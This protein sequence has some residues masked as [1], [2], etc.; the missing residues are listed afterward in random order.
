MALN[1]RRD[2]S[3]APSPRVGFEMSVLRMLAFRPAEGGGVDVEPVARP[4]PAAN[5]RARASVA[6]E[7]TQS[8]PSVPAAAAVPLPA[9]PAPQLP[10]KTPA[11]AATIADADRWLELVA[12]SGLRGPA[13]EL[14]EHAGFLSHDN[15]VL[16]LSLSAADEHLKAPALVRMLAEGIAPALGAAPQIRFESA[17]AA[18]QTLHQRK[19]QQRD[20]RQVAA[21]AAFMADP[22]V[23]RLV[24]QHGA[25][26]V[27]DSIRPFDE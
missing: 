5:E 8:A 26:V 7:A 23:Q 27:P 2:L 22:G 24:S 25:S 6:S 15:G 14:A 17:Q 10:T 13:R 1:G 19:T 3:L 11:D 9:P 18:S 12:G 20:A 16:R 21:E 4:K